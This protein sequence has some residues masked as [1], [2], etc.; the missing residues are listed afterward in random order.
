MSRKVRSIKRE[1][2]KQNAPG[3]IAVKL[4]D[5]IAC[6]NPVT[7]S[8]GNPIRPSVWQTLMSQPVPARVAFD[9]SKTA[10][11]IASEREAYEAARK[12]MCERYAEKDAD[13]KPKMVPVQMS[14]DGRSV[15]VPEHYDILEEKMVDFNKEL[16]ELHQTEVSL[17]AN[18]LNIESLSSINIPAAHLFALAWL[19]VE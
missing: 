6:T 10:K 3:T 11:A 19:I 2:E 12:G 18:Q 14:D 1:I 17:I 16:A 7:D 9:L 15:T 13:G 5:L 4:E 8:L